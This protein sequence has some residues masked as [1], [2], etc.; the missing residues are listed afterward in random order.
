MESPSSVQA[1]VVCVKVFPASFQAFCRLSVVSL[2]PTRRPT[3]PSKCQKVPA[4][5]LVQAWSYLLPKELVKVSIVT[6]RWRQESKSL[7]V[8]RIW[9][10]LFETEFRSPPVGFFSTDH[11]ETVGNIKQVRTW[12]KCPRLLPIINALP[13]KEF[14]SYEMPYYGYTVSCKYM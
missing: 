14:H 13:E 2:N 11:R 3:E 4:V 8:Q 10:R 5:L 9:Q 6:T 7:P 1:G 12:G